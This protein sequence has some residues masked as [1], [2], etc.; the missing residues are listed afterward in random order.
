MTI[1]SSTLLAP[2]ITTPSTGIFS[3]G[4]TR[5]RSPI[6]IS[7]KGTSSSMPST[8][9]RRAVF[10]ASPRRARIALPVLL[11][12]RSSSTWPM[13]TSAVMTAAASKYTGG[14]PCVP[15]SAG[16]NQCGNKSE[17]TLKP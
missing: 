1:D 7:A 2:S 5:M 4:R 3:P 8:R 9:T 16:D 11:R 14:M 12:A 10:G 15:R 6:W 13:S 17:A